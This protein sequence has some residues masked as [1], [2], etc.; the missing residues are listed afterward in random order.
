MCTQLSINP[1]EGT[2]T[3]KWAKWYTVKYAPT[4]KKGYSIG[5]SPIHLSKAKFA[6]KIQ[7]KT[8]LKSLCMVIFIG[9]I[10][11]NSIITTIAPNIARTPPNLSGIDL[12]IA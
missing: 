2:I 6:I 10:K 7:K 12:N 9:S 11:G 1:K 3:K 5:I 4:V 8:L